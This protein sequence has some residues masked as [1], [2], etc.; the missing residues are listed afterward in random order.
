MPAE[1]EL[2]G[3]LL[4]G[5]PAWVLAVF[6]VGYVIDN[7]IKSLRGTPSERT[8]REVVTIGQRRVLE[9]L[10]RMNESCERVATSL[11]ELRG[12]LSVHLRRQRRKGN[13]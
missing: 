2:L 12:M 13:P 4:S 8:L 1:P 5:A 10:D 9:G 11:S 6:A 3:K 7:L